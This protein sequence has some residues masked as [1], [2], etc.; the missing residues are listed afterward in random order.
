MAASC[1]KCSMPTLARMADG[2]VYCMNLCGYSRAPLLER[3]KRLGQ[4]GG[5]W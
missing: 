3:L 2:G 5:G 1:P 4:S